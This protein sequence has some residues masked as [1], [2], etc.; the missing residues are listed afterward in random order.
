[1]IPLWIYTLQKPVKSIYLELCV[2][3][4]KWSHLH[5]LSLQYAVRAQMCVAVPK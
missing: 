4:M 5:F 2:Y 3:L 1:M